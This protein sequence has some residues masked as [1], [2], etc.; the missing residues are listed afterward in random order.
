MIT[1][2]GGGRESLLLLLLFFFNITC[3]KIITYVIFCLD[4]FVTFVGWYLRFVMLLRAGRRFG[5]ASREVSAIAAISPRLQPSTAPSALRSAGR[6]TPARITMINSCAS[7]WHRRQH[8]VTM[9]NS[10]A[11]GRNNSRD[12]SNPPTGDGSPTGRARGCGLRSY[13]ALRLRPQPLAQTTG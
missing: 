6:L 2:E 9:V 7:G 8:I 11:G 13:A 1:R 3:S 4:F 5:L 10:G 12:K